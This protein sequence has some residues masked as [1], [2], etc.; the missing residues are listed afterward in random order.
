MGPMMTSLADG[1]VPQ[2]NSRTSHSV[3]HAMPVLY[4]L[5]R[6]IQPPALSV[7]PEL[8]AFLKRLEPCALLA[9]ALLVLE[10][11]CHPEG[12]IRLRVRVALLA[13]QDLEGLPRRHAPCRVRVLM[14]AGVRSIAGG[15]PRR[16]WVVRVGRLDDIVDLQ[17]DS[18][19]RHDA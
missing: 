12:N 14:Q 19:G 17:R 7:L 15:G 18:Y 3:I 1:T 13:L 8:A 11:E 6:P 10:L 9:L 5:A 16:R 2:Q 4:H